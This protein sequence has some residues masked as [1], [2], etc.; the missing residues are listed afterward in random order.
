MNY[1]T[2]NAFETADIIIN[3]QATLFPELPKLKVIEKSIS[4]ADS[5]IKNESSLDKQYLDFYQEVHFI[6]Q[7]KHSSQNNMDK[8]EEIIKQY[9]QKT[10]SQNIL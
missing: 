8:Q 5:I 6:L 4:I 10:I 2:E 7:N 9:E 3:H 1:K